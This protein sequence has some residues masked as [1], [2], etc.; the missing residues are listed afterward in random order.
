[1]NKTVE[2]SC[3]QEVTKN[4]TPVPESMEI[5][6]IPGNQ[7]NVADLETIFTLKEQEKE[8]LLE[9]AANYTRNTLF[10]AKQFVSD[11]DLRLGKS[12]Q[13]AVCNELK[14]SGYHAERFWETY[15]GCTRVRTA[16]RHKRQSV[17]QAVRKSFFSKYIVWKTI[18]N[19]ST[20][21]TS[22]I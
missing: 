6:T 15:G 11:D 20:I 8:N 1:M 21:L 10:W 4:Q 22:S 12:I 9:T 7:Q 13:V 3:K 14:L 18:F 17:V 19:T 2:I 16:I 5:A